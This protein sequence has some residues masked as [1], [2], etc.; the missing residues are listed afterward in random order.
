M[1]QVSVEWVT[2]RRIREQHWCTFI[3][4][5]FYYFWCWKKI[6]IL[7]I[8][9]FF[10]H[11]ISMTTKCLVESIWFSFFI[12]L[13]GFP[14]NFKNLFIMKYCIPYKGYSMSYNWTTS[15]WHCKEKDLSTFRKHK[16]ICFTQST[17]NKA[18][19]S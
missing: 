3:Y 18:Q 4:C 9:S 12:C 14:L 16:I 15:T 7:S 13:I 2:A 1:I 6:I 5:N 17:Y 11:I 19:K 8:F 10:R